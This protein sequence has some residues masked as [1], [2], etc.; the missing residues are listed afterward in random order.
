MDQPHAVTVFFTKQ[1]N[2]AVV[3]GFLVRHLGPGDALIG[4][5]PGVDAALDV[6][7][8]LDADRLV[9]GKVEAQTLRRHQRTRLCGVFT[10]HIAQGTLEQVS[11]RVITL[12]V[13]TAHAIDNRL[14]NRPTGYGATGNNT[15]VHYDPGD[16]PLRVGDVHRTCGRGQRTGVTH[17]SAGFGIKR[18]AVEDDLDLGAHRC[19]VLDVVCADDSRYGP[20]A[21]ELR[22]TDECRRAQVE[23]SPDFGVSTTLEVGVGA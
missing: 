22:K 1:R 18:R 3:E 4:T 19:V 15:N 10:Q 9:V 5:H 14:G 6:A 7:L 13:P 17:L 8:L 23:F 21:F 2:S 11:G 12:D 16:G 20:R